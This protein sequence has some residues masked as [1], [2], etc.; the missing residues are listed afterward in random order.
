MVEW[1]SPCPVAATAKTSSPVARGSW[2]AG[3]VDTGSLL[4][5]ARSLPS[6]HLKA[7]VRG[8]EGAPWPAGE[9]PAPLSCSLSPLLLKGHPRV[10]LAVGRY[11]AGEVWSAAPCLP[12]QRGA[13][14]GSD[15]QVE[16]LS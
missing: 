15:N 4:V 7:G 10:I 14:L 12:L 13:S 5:L 6:R 2:Q 16:S 1:G 11:R 9:L 8:S 3:S